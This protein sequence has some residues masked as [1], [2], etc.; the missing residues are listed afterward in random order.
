VFKRFVAIAAFVS[1][2]LVA[3]YAGQVLSSILQVVSLARHGKL[4]RPAARPSVTYILRNGA[5]AF[6]VCLGLGSVRI[7]NAYFLAERPDSEKAQSVFDRIVGTFAQPTDACTFIRQNRIVGKV[8]NAWPEG[9]F[10]AWSQD[11]EPASGRIPL[12]VLI[13][14]RAQ[15]AYS[16]KAYSDWKDICQCVTI[17]RELGISGREPNDKEWEKIGEWADVQLRQRGV[18]VALLPIRFGI[19]FYVTKALQSHPNWRT[20]FRDSAHA[21][22][23]DTSTPQGQRV[24]DGIVTGQT[25]FPDEFTRQT[26]LAYHWLEC[27]TTTDEFTL[28]LAHAA[29]AFH[30]RPSLSSATLLTKVAAK[31]DELVPAICSL[32]RDYVEQCSTRTDDFAGQD[33]LDQVQAGQQMTDFLSKCDARQNDDEAVGLS[34]RGIRTRTQQMGV[35]SVGNVSE[36]A[37]KRI[38]LGAECPE[39]TRDR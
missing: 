12:Q 8:F 18:G 15:A 28:G 7:F 30:L 22:L 19:S 37:I 29:E 9:G 21:L 31:H 39:G 33:S 20:A 2:P 5:V 34:P 32:C 26:G 14:G 27:G 17:T 13:D 25:V 4:E 36:E 10:I 6:V 35:G 24:L 16:D 3:A 23:L 38:S 1:C 11:P